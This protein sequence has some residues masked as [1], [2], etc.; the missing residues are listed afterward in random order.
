MDNKELL[1]YIGDINQVFSV[2][3]YKMEGGK[4]QGVEAID[5]NN[6]S[7]LELTILPDRGMDIY[8][9][10][11]KGRCLNYLSKSGITA[12]QYFDTT[13]RGFLP[14]FY[15]GFLTTCGLENIGI[16]C[17]DEGESLGMHGSIAN[18]PAE[19]VNIIHDTID[20]APAVKITGTMVNAA[21]F[22]SNL[23]LTRTYEIKYG[24]N[25]V[26]FYDQIENF[27]YKKSP[28]MILYHFNMGY[29]LLSEN[30]EVSIP[31]KNIIPRTEHAAKHIDQ[32]LEVTKPEFNYEEMCYYHEVEPDKTG[33][34]TVGIKNK[35]EKL[36]LSII[37]DRNQLDH[38]VQWKMFGKGE[39]AMGLEPG[40]ATIDGRDDARKNGSLKWLEPGETVCNRL[41]ISVCE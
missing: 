2:K 23:K 22:G 11:F 25:E 20:H 4:R 16:S 3:R 32:Y 7:G 38:F 8:Q 10:K 13:G 24:V 1:E 28:Y 18:T 40:N 31:T 26:N 34:A 17:E 39:Y 15:A 19:H 5:I 35:E 30:S 6:G 29:P 37:Y 33:F 14:S 21:L 9:L 41:K 12:P 36:S 27:G